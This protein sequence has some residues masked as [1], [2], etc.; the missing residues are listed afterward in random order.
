[1]LEMQVGRVI[2][3]VVCTGF[4]NRLC[5]FMCRSA[6]QLVS[7]ERPGGESESVYI[8]ERASP[9]ECGLQEWKSLQVE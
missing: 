9:F 6:V 8:M 4:G 5:V 2:L 7:V 1:M 3:L